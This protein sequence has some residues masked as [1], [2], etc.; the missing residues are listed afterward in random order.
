VDQNKNSY[1]AKEGTI[2]TDLQNSAN[3]SANSVSV[4]IGAGTLPGKS[5][6]AGMSGVGMG[7]DKGSA[8]STTTAGIS[9]VA[10]NTQARTGDK[11]TSIAPIFNKDQVQKEVAAQVAITSEFGKQA[12][13]AVGDYAGNQLKDLSSKANAETDP[14]KKAALQAEAA[15]W[16][17]GGAYRVAMHTAVGGLTS[18]L[19]GAAGAGTASAA[20]PTIDQLQGQLKTA[21]KNA[22]MGDSA[23]NVISSL[24]G[25]TTAAAIGAAASGGTTAGAATAFNSDMN[26]RQ[27]HPTEAKLIKDSAKR[28]ADKRGIS[29]DQAEAELTQQSLRNIDSAHDIRLGQ[30]SAHAQAFLKDLGAGQ[31]TFDPLTGQRFELFAADEATRQNHAMFG[32]YTKL[33]T[34][35]K[36][37]LDRAYDQAFKPAGAQTIAGLNGTN[38]GALTG[39]DLALN[40]AARDFSHMRKEPQVVQWAVLGQIRQ[41]RAQNLQT[42]QLLLNELQGMNQ[43]AEVGPQAAQRR[44]EIVNQLNLL[45]QEN[46]VMRQA[47]VE[48]LKAMGSAGTTNPAKHREWIEGSGEAIAASRLTLQG[49][50]S[51]SI[52]GRINALKG[53]VEEVQAASAVAKAEAQAVSKARVDN[54]ANADASYAGGV[55]VRPRDG[56]VPVGTD[57][58]NT[59]IAKHLIDV[60]I[61]TFKGQPSSISGGHNMDNFNQAV[62]ANGGQVQGAPKEVAPG[63]FE[64]E[65]KMPGTV[66]KNPTK[67]AYD[68]AKYSDAQMASMANEAV[69]RA[70]YQWNKAGTGKVPDI[71]FVDVNGIK[72]EVPISSHKGQVYVPTA[73][74]SGK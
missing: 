65:Y 62:R 54:N 69:G 14:G 38:K 58:I 73:Y 71:Q 10:G 66:G 47:S 21:I 50:S 59:P 5:A 68:P 27:L 25:G 19:A 30:D 53:A 32:Q 7:S 67:T 55:P 45:E 22:G 31:A 3:Y 72:F 12:S 20:A 13:K 40:D 51:A 60:E 41:E 56:Q 1:Q 34:D 23:A 63:I 8:Q 49:A 52:T 61:K 9:G 70:I 2:T 35:T 4:G 18:G 39:S 44:G 43:R 6:S 15:K 16:E 57:Q 29:V 48:Q 46:Q 11:S 42:Q 28:Y 33:S 74:P 26:N 64:I 36:R 24:A 17:E 37:V